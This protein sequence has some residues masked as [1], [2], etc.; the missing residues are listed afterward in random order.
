V[1]LWSGRGYREAELISSEGYARDIVISLNIVSEFSRLE[2][3]REAGCAS[4][5][6]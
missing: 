1:T 6:Q 2:C 3:W 4:G 5:S